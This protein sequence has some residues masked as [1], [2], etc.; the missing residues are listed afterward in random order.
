[1]V[2]AFCKEISGIER[3]YSFENDLLMQAKIMELARK[4]NM[5]KKIAYMDELSHD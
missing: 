3:N 5:E 1:M 2:N 4:S